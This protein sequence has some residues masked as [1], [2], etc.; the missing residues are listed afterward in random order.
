MRIPKL[1]VCCWSIR[2]ACCGDNREEAALEL[3]RADAPALPPFVE[4][5]LAA[6]L[7]DPPGRNGVKC[8]TA[9]GPPA[10]AV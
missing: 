2:I 8:L 1:S 4:S 3:V 5:L 9:D 6:L 7:L 10:A